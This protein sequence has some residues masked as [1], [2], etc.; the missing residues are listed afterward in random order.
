MC[1]TKL[2]KIALE[3]PVFAMNKVL[4]FIKA[5]QHVDPLLEASRSAIIC[6]HNSTNILWVKGYQIQ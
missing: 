1:V 4:S 3:S 6:V 5:I 2:N